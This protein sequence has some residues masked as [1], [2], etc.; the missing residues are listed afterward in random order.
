MNNLVIWGGT[1]GL[2]SH[3]WIHRH[4]AATAA[5]LG[6]SSCWVPDLPSSADFVTN[7]STVIGINIWSQ[8][9]PYREGADYVL[10]NFDGSHPLCQQLLPENLLRLQVWTNDADGEEWGRCR[11]YNRQARTLFQPWGCDLLAEEFMPP[12]YNQWSREAVFVGAIWGEASPYGELGNVDAIDELRDALGRKGMAF[13]HHTHIS[14]S[15]NIRV[16]REA[17]LAPAVAGGWQVQNGYLPCRV[18]KNPSY[19]AAMFTNI[20]VVNELFRQ[21][22]VEGETVGE[23]I[24]NTLRLTR[25]EY[26][27]LVIEQQRICSE[28]TYRESLQSI[29]KALQAGR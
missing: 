23:Q 11:R 20:P 7:E 8:H 25:K 12:V 24:E 6:I 21:A 10:H 17:R 28:F 13:K 4:F 2:E 14:D 9:I 27:D 29:F 19:G 3:R 5:K 18:F 1:D 22:R 15:E 16:I 26:E